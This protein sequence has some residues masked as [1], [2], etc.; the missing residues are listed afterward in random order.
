MRRRS[1][2]SSSSARRIS[3]ILVSGL[4][5][6]GSGAGGKEGTRPAE[7]RANDVASIDGIVAALYESISGPAGPRDWDRLRSLFLPG[8]RLIPCRRPPG[9]DATEARVLSVED[10]IKLVEPNTKDR[11]FFEREVH[12]RAERFGAVAHV[13]S[14]YESRQAATDAQPFVRGINSIQLFFDG[15]RWWVVTIYWDSERPDQ[16]IPP[17][18]LPAKP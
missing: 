9:A 12:R 10:F 4:L 2:G 3:L 5:A 11:G 16:P 1:P 6:C 13:F 14:T 18:Y 7:A 15:K 17:E 8:A